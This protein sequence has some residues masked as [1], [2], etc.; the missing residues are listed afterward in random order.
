[1][2]SNEAINSRDVR[3]APA[4]HGHRRQRPKRSHNKSRDGSLEE[5][6]GGHRRE[7]YSRKKYTRDWSSNRPPLFLIYWPDIKLGGPYGPVKDK[8]YW[9]ELVRR[10]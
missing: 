3:R 8:M 1:M 6:F 10:S 4:C 9:P 7:E 2:A 5:G